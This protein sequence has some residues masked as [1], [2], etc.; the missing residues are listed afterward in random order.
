[1]GEHG[2]DGVTESGW[3]K[4]LNC[5]V[6]VFLFLWCVPCGLTVVGW[7]EA[8]LLPVPLVSMVD[9]CFELPFRFGA[10]PYLY[11]IAI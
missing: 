11:F 5:L 9:T 2:L 4:M 10:H 3:E 8:F 1:M 6:C 7:E